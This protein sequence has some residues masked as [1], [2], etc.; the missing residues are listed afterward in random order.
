VKA[1]DVA[2]KVAEKAQALTNA[3]LKDQK[4]AAKKQVVESSSD[5]EEDS[6]DEVGCV[7]C[8]SVDLCS[9]IASLVFMFYFVHVVVVSV[10]F[11]FL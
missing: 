1:E 2:K 5:E 10:C 9:Q 11:L 3:V 4:K 7:L 8:Y 6:D